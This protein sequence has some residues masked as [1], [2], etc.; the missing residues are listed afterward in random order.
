MHARMFVLAVLT[1]AVVLPTKAE[2][3]KTNAA[4]LPRIRVGADGLETEAGKPF[5][6]FGLTYYRPGTGWAPQVWKQ[7]DAEATR[8]DFVRM[9]ELGVNCV[10]VFLSYG[11][12]LM[13]T[14]RLSPEGLAKFDQLLEIAERSGHLRASDRARSL[15]GPAGLGQDRIAMRTKWCCAAWRNSGGSSLHVTEVAQ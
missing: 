1:L 8:R 3:S 10:R 6:P 14:N 9:K 2:S 13:E 11:S 12:F 4:A 15:G 7:F 5:V